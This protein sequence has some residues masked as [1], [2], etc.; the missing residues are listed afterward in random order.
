[1]SAVSGDVL[2]CKLAVVDGEGSSDVSGEGS[3]DVS[4]DGG[5]SVENY[6]RLW[7]VQLQLVS[8]NVSYAGSLE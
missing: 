6:S 8:G 5:V 1:V 4:D 7:F 2:T 3:S